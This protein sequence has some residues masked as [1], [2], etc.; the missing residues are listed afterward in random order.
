MSN[1]WSKNY[2]EYKSNSDRNKTL[3][4]EEHFDKIR[5]YSKDI[6]DN[7]KKSDMWRIQLTI[8]IKFISSIDSGEERVM[9]SKIDNIE[10]MMNDEAD[11]VIKELFDS[12]KNRYHN[13]LETMKGSGFVFDYVY[14]LCHKCHKMNPNCSGSYIDSPEWIENKKPTINPINKKIINAFNTL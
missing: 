10:V 2:I 14:L 9:H 4:I 1:F 12:L 13:N 5:L 7:R 6:I 3:S 11:E 8:A